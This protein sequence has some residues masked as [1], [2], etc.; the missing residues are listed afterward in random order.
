M[1]KKIRAGFSRA[2]VLGTIVLLGFLLDSAITDAPVKKDSLQNLRSAYNLYTWG[3]FSK[4]KSAARPPAPDNYREPLPPFV[5]ALYSALAGEER[6]CNDG[7][8]RASGFNSRAVKKIN[9]FWAVCVL[10]ATAVLARTVTK[11]DFAAIAALVLTYMCFLRNPAYIDRLIT[12]IPAS[13]CM[14]TCAL[15][16]GA[17]VRGR[18]PAAGFLAGTALGLLVLTKALFFYAIVPLVLVTASYVLFAG[19]RAPAR[20]AAA[21]LGCLCCGVLITVCP[22]LV[23]NSVHFGSFQV[24]SRGGLALYT[25]ALINRMDAFEYKAAFYCWGPGPY[26][27]LV[28]A[29]PLAV[30]DADHGPGGRAVRLACSGHSAPA[31]RDAIVRRQGR[32]QDAVSFYAMGR[33]RRNRLQRELKKEGARNPVQAAD[34]LL[35]DRALAMII[36]HPFRHAA[37]TLPLA[38]RG[39][40]G[41]Y[42]G[43]LSAVLCGLSYAGFVVVCLYAVLRK[44]RDLTVFAAVPFFLLAF[45]AF[46]SNN[47]PRF[48][49]PAIPFLVISL[50]FVLVTGVR[51]LREG[52][53]GRTLHGDA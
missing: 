5:T 25:R 50:M 19:G 15:C 51:R 20:N 40:W 11:S 33:A 27:W 45:N 49:T 21:G 22:W 42:G 38:W 4:Q 23:R 52:P 46:L 26:R 16:L 31:A 36:R 53:A 41:F 14:L 34:A 9:L 6:V 32:P 37:A 17:Y 30:S 29:T 2:L 1:N 3:V 8:C 47:L 44:S 18:S 39:M 28:R 35:R 12:E 43:V 7:D 48:N 13:A 10:C 24:T